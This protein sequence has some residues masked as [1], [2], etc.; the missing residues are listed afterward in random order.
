MAPPTEGGPRQVHG[1]LQSRLHL[2]YGAYQFEMDQD[3]NNTAV[4]KGEELSNFSAKHVKCLPFRPP[5]AGKPA[6]CETHRNGLQDVAE[7]A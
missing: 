7:E 6:S 5:L 1:A 3:T 4:N 2:Y